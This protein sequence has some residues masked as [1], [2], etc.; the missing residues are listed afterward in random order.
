[1]GDQE[2]D[3]SLATPN[4]LSAEPRVRSVC[5]RRIC[6]TGWAVCLT[7]SVTQVF[8]GHLALRSWCFSRKTESSEAEACFYSLCGPSRAH[9]EWGPTSVCCSGLLWTSGDGGRK[10]ARMDR[11]QR[12]RAEGTEDTFPAWKLG[13]LGMEPVL[14]WK[15]Y[16]FKL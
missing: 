6:L 4:C 7:Y 16:G 11:E 8:C 14:K 10:A 13:A 2:A 9:A 5:Y 3:T 12:P 1:M 15:T